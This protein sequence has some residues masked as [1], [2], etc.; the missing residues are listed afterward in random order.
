[1]RNGGNWREWAHVTGLYFGKV[2]ED[3]GGQL[4]R[5]LTKKSFMCHVRELIS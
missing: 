4:S 5:Y 3:E 2:M 1:M